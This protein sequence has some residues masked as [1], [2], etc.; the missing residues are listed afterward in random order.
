MKELTH[1]N[2]LSSV[3][4]NKGIR[5]LSPAVAP[6]CHCPMRMAAITAKSIKGLSSLLVGMP[7][8]TTHVR[9]FNPK[10]EGKGGELHWLYVLDDKEVVFGCREGLLKALK[11][12]DQEGA[13]AILVILTCIPELIGEDIEGIIHEIQP[14]LKARVTAVMLGQF[15]HFSH[16]PGYWKTMEALGT[17]MEEQ[18]KDILRVNVLG[19]SPKEE[20]ITVPAVL[21][22]LECRGFVLRYLA[23]GTTLEE[24]QRAPDA[25]LNLVLSPYVHPLAVRMEREFGIPYVTLHS[26]YGIED[27]DRAYEK[28]AQILGFDWNGEFDRERETACVLEKEAKKWLQGL[29][30]VLSSGNEL[31]LALSVYLTKLG[32][33]PLLLHLEEFYPEDKEHAKELLALEKNPP[34]CRMVNLRGEYSMLEKLSPDLCLGMLPPQNRTIPNLGDMNRFYGKNGYERTAELLKEMLAVFEKKK[35]E[36][37]YGTA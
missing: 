29:G 23:P 16:P 20:H 15:K 17:L 18:K 10:P 13:K 32:M 9:L 8:C 37:D 24:I 35:G 22:H 30:Y 2:R 28:I 27:I 36:G 21:V 11:K 31:P 5:F 14:Q 25:S 33:E 19:R 12:M 4:S 6:G 7:E 26:R 34:I 3:K 1:L